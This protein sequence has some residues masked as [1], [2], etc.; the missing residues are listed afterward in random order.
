M[1]NLKK[2]LIFGKYKI[3]N[4]LGIGSFSNVFQGKNVMDGK[5]AAIKIEDCKTKG[6]FLEGEA[7]ILFE[8]KGIGVP[9]VLSFGNFGKY[10]VL[11]ETLFGNSL[12][13][14]FSKSKVNFHIKDICMIAIQL[15]EILEYIHSKYIIHRDIKPANIVIDYETKRTISLIDFG[16]A[17]KYRSGRTG[18]HINFSIPK[19]AIGTINFC[20]QNA[21]RGGQQSRKDDLESVAYTLIYLAKK[22]LPLENLKEKNIL[23]RVNKAFRIKKDITPEVLCLGLPQE[24]CEYL[25][26]VKQLKFKEDPDYKYLK[27]LFL[28]T[29]YRLGFN[30][31]YNF[32]WIDNKDKIDIQSKNKLLLFER[33][34]RKMS[35]CCRI[36]KKIE[37]NIKNNFLNKNYLKGDIS[38]NEAEN[39]KDKSNNSH[40][41]QN[42]R[43]EAKSISPLNINLNIENEKMKNNDVPITEIDKLLFKLETQNKKTVLNTKFIKHNRILNLKNYKKQSNNSRNKPFDFDPINIPLKVITSFPV[44]N[45]I[46]INLNNDKYKSN[47]K[48]I[49]HITYNSPLKIGDNQNND[50]FTKNDTVYYQRPNSNNSYLKINNKFSRNDHRVI[51][52]NLKRVNLLQNENNKIITHKK[53]INSNINNKNTE[54]LNNTES[55][56]LN[57]LKVIS[58]YSNNNNNGYLKKI[59]LNDKRIKNNN[60]KIITNDNIK[61]NIKDKNN[62]FYPERNLNKIILNKKIK[63]ENNSIK[64]NLIS[65]SNSIKQIQ[66]YDKKNAN[67]ANKIKGNYIK[68]D[69]RLFKNIFSR[70]N[71]SNPYRYKSPK[72]VEDL[73]F[74]MGDRKML[75]LNCRNNSSIYY[76]Q[77]TSNI[78]IFE[79]AKDTIDFQHNDFL[80]ENKVR[81]TNYSRINSKTHL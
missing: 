37:G 62:P 48:R 47:S 15:I 1:L 33:R 32:S 46:V 25:K 9:E 27:S 65:N 49:M 51:P 42:I 81:S 68:K 50:I 45:N 76:N 80:F 43:G 26:Y 24:F 63:T 67:Y 31:D 11:V 54:Y 38:I 64:K 35:P 13:D 57:K 55:I 8:L 5:N 71:Y 34:K 58:N 14:L 29:L 41:S 12:D 16:F 2:K 10:K 74:K 75:N 69:N 66:N 70:N 30:L 60:I 7:Y 4:L 18:N 17:K 6:N 20:S 19:I 52:K 73:K 39:N 53:I 56:E 40:L 59:K 79:L 61:N 28:N 77:T 3:L 36:I 22:R 23:E 21:N 44:T 78:N 72:T